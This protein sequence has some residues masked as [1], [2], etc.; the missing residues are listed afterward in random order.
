MAK[1]KG[2]SRE[3]MKNS[4]TY[5]SIDSEIDAAKYLIEYMNNNKKQK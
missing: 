3:I 4:A 2:G 5:E 1:I